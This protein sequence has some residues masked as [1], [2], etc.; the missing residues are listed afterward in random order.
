MPLAVF[1]F[2]DSGAK[3]QMSHKASFAVRAGLGL[4]VVLSATRTALSAETHRPHGGMLRYPDV[5]ATHIVFVYA[6]DLWLVGRDGGVATLLASPPG[7]ELHP[8]FSGD[9]QTIAFVGN[10][11]GN[12]DLYVLPTLGGISRRVTY[13][14]ASEQLC[15]WAPDGR[16]IFMTNGFAGLPRQMQLFTIS[17]EGGLPEQLPVPYGANGAISPDGQ[18]L[19]YQPHSIDFR[20]WKRYR[21]GMATDI[22]L[23][24]LRTNES[25]KITDWEGTDTLPMWHGSTIYY[26]SDEGEPYRLNIWAYDTDSRQRRQ[27]TKFE[28]FD[29]KWPSI[30]PGPTGKGEIVFQYGP[31]LMLLDLATGQSKA[32]DVIIPGDRPL[33]RPKKTDVSNFLSSWNISATGKRALFEARGDVWTVPAKEGSPRRLTRTSGAAERDPIWSPDGRWIAYLSDAT[34]EYEIYVLQSDGV[35]EPRQITKDGTHFRFL[36]SWSPDSKRIVFTDKAG[37]MFL[38]DA[39]TGASTLVDTDPWTGQLR[40]SWSH[41]SRWMVYSKGS[42]NRNNAIWLYNVETGAKQQVTSDM[43]NDTWPTFDREGDFL[44]FSSNRDF[45]SP[46]YED[47]GTTWVYAATDKLYA[48]PLRKDVKSPLA[49]KSDEEKWEEKKDGE[50]GKK[51]ENGKDGEAENQTGE[52]DGNGSEG[53][54]DKPADEKKDADNKSDKKKKEKKPVEIDLE[55]FEARAIELPAKRGNYSQLSVNDKKQL[56]YVRSSPRGIEDRSSIFI[57]D[58]FDEKADTKEEKTVA[59]DAGSYAISSDGK[60]LL[61]RKGEGAGPPGRRS[62]GGAPGFYIVSAAADQKLDKPVSMAGMGIDVDPRAEWRQIFKEAWRLHRDYFYVANMHGVDWK[63]VGRQY[64]AMLEDCTSR[65]D[66]TYVI[67]EMISELN[68]GHAYVRG[69]GDVEREPQVP[70]GLLG[71][72][73]TFENGA[74]RIAKIYEGAAWDTDARSPLRVPGHEVN[75][76]EYLLAINGVPLDARRD[77][78]SALVGLAGRGVTLTVS[79]R[80]AKDEDAR[81][82]VVKTLDS[83]VPQRYRAWIEKN[84]AYVA[85]QTR[86]RVGYIY[87]PNTG[88]DGQNDLFRQFQGQ[89]HLA[90]LII[91]ERWNGGGQIP[92]RF[93]ELLNRPATNYWARRDGNDWPWPP[94]AHQGPKCMLINGLAGSGGDMFPW[95]FRQSGLGK[96]I[97]TRT[98]GGL[99]GITGIP[100]F[101][102]GGNTNV[103]TFGFYKNNGTWGVEG[104]GVDPDL[105]VIDDPAKMVGGKD[106]QLDAAIGHILYEL[107]HNPYVPP[108]RPAP[109]DRRGMGIPVEDR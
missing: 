98:W 104:H 60:K 59:A 43:F 20:T 84:R 4:L 92:T 69:F 64:E 78:W 108:R 103:P 83:E 8:K 17:P 91:D 89:K 72:D 99:V 94:D 77:P 68:V 85:D 90:A 14:P 105:E 73:Y 5:S 15:E 39:E 33:L 9:G 53:T 21:G 3:G 16:L 25:R 45:G 102:D 34:G 6:N 18:W 48:V 46:V 7:Q 63:A 41:D 47:L 22:W 29:V 32:V 2:H 86:G 93:I 106:P 28:E 35:G 80:P 58:L 61:I 96:L 79:T 50:E 95:L 100:Q 76:G 109:P 57:I 11:E 54:E 62:G 24:N 55:G 49:P 31:R 36:V 74:Y 51:D 67:G 101:I 44:Y 75:E 56:L 52:R 82:V 30:G 88:V 19:A 1:T 81:E 38:C 71:C 26:L 10:Y 27:I 42:D 12:R 65:D 107:E 13:H 40:P 66:L 70:V 23:L 37:A 97:G 87:V